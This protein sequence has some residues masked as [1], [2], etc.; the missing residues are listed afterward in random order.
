VHLTCYS[1]NSGCDDLTTWFSSKA[2]AWRTISSMSDEAVANHIEADG[3]DLLIDL[4]G[5][6]SGS[7][8][9][10]FA[11]RP[12]PVQASWCGYFDT[13]GMSTIDYVIGN[14]LLIPEHDDQYYTEQIVRLDGA[15][16]CYTPQTDLP[17]APTPALEA[18][19]VTFGC[20][21]R[22]AKVT[23][24]VVALWSRVLAAVPDSRLCLKDKSFVDDGVR[25]RYIR[26]F[27]EHGI[28]DDRL[29][30]AG[31]S[32]HAQYFADYAAIDIA[33]DP[34]PFN[35]GATTVEALWMGVPVV[36][37]TGDRFAGRMGL[38]HLSAAGLDEL[39][40]ASPDEYVM[41]ASHLAHNVE[42]LARLR[43]GLR[44]QVQASALCDGPRFARSAE[45]AF[46]QMWWAWC[47]NPR[48]PHQ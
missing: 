35:G 48:A 30:F 7:R 43:T 32:S 15:Y 46:R 14:H 26:Q 11:Y 16:A 20:F 22:I 10:L 47:D 8:L 34:F 41:I 17:V 13:T 21:N 31:A 24:A 33:L 28:A 27:A 2:D 40:A 12:A 45:A 18:G 5:H 4:S 38:A 1:N 19:H 9:P 39:I 25:S 29:L 3:I 36:T 23:P 6:T 37:L 42:R 44:E